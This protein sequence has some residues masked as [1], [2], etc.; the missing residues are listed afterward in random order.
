MHNTEYILRDF[1]YMRFKERQNESIVEKSEQLSSGGWG[2]E[3]H[4]D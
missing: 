3:V 4:K 1:I 2:G